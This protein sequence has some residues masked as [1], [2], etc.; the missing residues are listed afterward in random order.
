MAEFTCGYQCDYV[1]NASKL[2]LGRLI[3][4]RDEEG[5]NGAAWFEPSWFKDLDRWGVKCCGFIGIRSVYL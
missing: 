1:K 2:H 5:I 3:R 4:Q